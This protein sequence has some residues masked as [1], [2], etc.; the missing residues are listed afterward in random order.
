[1]GDLQ[2]AQSFQNNFNLICYRKNYRVWKNL[3]RLKLVYGRQIN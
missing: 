2:I 3:G 1:M